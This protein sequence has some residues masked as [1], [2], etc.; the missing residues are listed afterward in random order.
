[1]QVR[2]YKRKIPVAEAVGPAP[3]QDVTEMRPGEMKCRA[4]ERG[5]SIAHKDTAHSFLESN[6][7]QIGNEWRCTW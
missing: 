6:P 1:M 7:N 5:H 3:A 2:S 4:F